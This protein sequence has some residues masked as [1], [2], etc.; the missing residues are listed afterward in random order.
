MMNW[1]KENEGGKCNYNFKN[2]KYYWMK[3]V[4]KW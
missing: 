3:E 1:R 4:Y 2:K